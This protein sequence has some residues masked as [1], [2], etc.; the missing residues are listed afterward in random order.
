MCW[1][2]IFWV[3]PP[4]RPILLGFPISE[5]SDTCARLY[6]PL[7]VGVFHHF[8]K[9]IDKILFLSVPC[10][11][12][13]FSNIH[14]SRSHLQLGIP[15]SLAQKFLR[16]K[17]AEISETPGFKVLFS[18]NCWFI[19]Y[20]RKVLFLQYLLWYIHPFYRVFVTDMLKMN[21]I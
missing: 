8:H 7:K 1:R 3:A 12:N 17:T 14:H 10:A 9:K 16:V 20:I 18:S 11:E 2:I 21:K 6:Y 15:S 5:I 19:L 13:G 4:N